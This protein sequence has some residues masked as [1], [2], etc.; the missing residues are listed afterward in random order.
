MKQTI[1]SFCGVLTTNIFSIWDG[2]GMILH[3]NN[4]IKF[5]SFKYIAHMISMILAGIDC[6]INCLMILLSFIIYDKLY[7]NICCCHNKCMM[8]W[9]YGLIKKRLIKQHHNSL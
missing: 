3:G 7:F 4:F 2:I 8:V 6:V 5:K 1:L 9:G